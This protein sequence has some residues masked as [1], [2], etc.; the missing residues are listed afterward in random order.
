MDLDGAAEVARPACLEGGAHP[1]SARK[2]EFSP[3]SLSLLALHR[4][5]CLS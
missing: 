4:L 2:P 5:C 3:V 1:I